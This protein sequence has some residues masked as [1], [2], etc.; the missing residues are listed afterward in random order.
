MMHLPEEY[1]EMY[2]GHAIRISAAAAADAP[3]RFEPRIEWVE[4]VNTPKHVFYKLT[5]DE[6]TFADPLAAITYGV[7]L[8]KRWVD[9][10]QSTAAV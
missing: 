3:H 4:Q 8:V 6:S 7:N 2:R 9:R 1:E 5:P 10:M